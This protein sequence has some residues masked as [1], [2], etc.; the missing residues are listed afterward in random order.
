MKPG[1]VDNMPVGQWVR[2]SGDCPDSNDYV[3]F[4]GQIEFGPRLR[5]V[6]IPHMFNFDTL[7]WRHGPMLPT[8]ILNSGGFRAWDENRRKIWGQSCDAGGGNAFLSFDPTGTNPH[9]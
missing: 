2:I 3:L 8:A 7:S 1:W 6:A 4:K 5:A 9:G